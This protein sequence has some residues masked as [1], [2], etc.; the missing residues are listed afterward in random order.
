MKKA[1]LTLA[2]AVALLVLPGMASAQTSSGTLTVTATVDSSISLTFVSSGSGIALTGSGSS[3]ATMAFGN[4]QAYGGS[5]PA[6]VTKS[7]NGVTYWQLS[8]PFLVRVENANAPSSANYTL[9]AQLSAADAVNTW[10]INAVDISDGSS[11]QI[12]ATG[13]FDSNDSHTLYLRIPHS[14]AAGAISK[15]VTFTATAN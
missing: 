8:T 9:D 15:T 4:V 13:N 3:A 12:T 6:G 7:V 10:L 5:V 2:V 14:A 1:S 11:A